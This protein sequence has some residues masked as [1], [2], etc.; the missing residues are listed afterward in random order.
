MKKTVALLLTLAMVMSLALSSVAIA[1]DGQKTLLKVGIDS[2]LDTLNP[3]AVAKPSKSFVCGTL[4]Q[5]LGMAL[6]VGSNEM[7]GILMK[8]WEQVDDL[9]YSITLYDGIKDSAGN[10]FTASDV[11]FSFGKYA[12]QNANYIESI[13]VADDTHFTMVLNTLTPGTFQLV[14]QDCFMVTE[15]GY[16]ASPDGLS[17]TACGTAPYQ[18]KEFIEGS[19]I[20]LEK[21]TDYWQSEELNHPS[22]A[23]NVD[24]IEFNI[25]T[26]VTQMGLALEQGTIQMGMWISDSLLDGLKAK[27]NLTLFAAPCTESRG[28]M[29]NM[30]EESPFYDNLPLRQAVAYAIDNATAVIACCYGYGD[31]SKGIIGSEAVSV[32]YNPDWN[33]YP[34]AYDVEKAKALLEEVGYAPGELSLRLLS[35]NNTLIKTLWEVIQANLM[36]IGINAS[37]DIYDGSTYGSYRDGTSG[38]YELAYCGAQMGGYAT[39]A[40]DTVFNSSN[41]DSGRTWFGLKDDTLQGLYDTVTSAGGFT[42]E[43]IDS[44][45]NYVADNCLY[46]QIIDKPTYCVFDNTKIVSV[47]NDNF[48]FMRVGATVLQ[49]GYDVFAQ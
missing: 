31:V 29:F 24:Q 4:Y 11:V 22:Y 10:P 20:T 7:V 12:E 8:E 9:T 40:W 26:E 34:Y 49:D 44:F 27:E 37:I 18:V 35:N 5:S 47:Y 25:L 38:M 43:N 16:N 30:T 46:Y 32:G 17:A 36:A 1:E 23:A 41:R 33:T 21:T 45:Y 19:K 2:T 15:V 48:N 39:R 6:E 28:I 3:W 42:P 13:D 14:A